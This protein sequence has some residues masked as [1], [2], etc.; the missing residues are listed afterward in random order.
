[1]S[2]VNSYWHFQRVYYLHSSKQ[3]YQFT[4]KHSTTQDLKI[5][6]NTHECCACHNTT[7]FTAVFD[8]STVPQLIK[9][10]TADTV[11]TFHY[12]IT[13]PTSNQLH[14]P[15]R[16]SQN[17]QNQLLKLQFQYKSTIHTQ[18]SPVSSSHSLSLVRFHKQKH[19]SNIHYTLPCASFYQHSN[20]Q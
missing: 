19:F 13:L 9:S 11:H 6:K 5:Q 14:V 4:T 8:S 20:T 12:Y 7:Q 18:D 16:F 17:S 10:F 1:M 2:T 15:D 3:L